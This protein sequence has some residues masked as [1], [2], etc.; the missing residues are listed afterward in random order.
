MTIATPVEHLPLSPGV[1]VS[2]DAV[3]L[4]WQLED[5]GLIVDLDDD[6]RLVLLGGV[7]TLFGPIAGA[8]VF[9]WLQDEIT[10]FDYWRLILGLL[11]IAIVL[12]F[13]QGIA[14]FARDRLG[15]WF[16]LR[17]LGE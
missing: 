2:M 8:S 15:P 9:T 14:G 3:R 16:G 11:I 4:S 17:G 1:A 10:R 12:A 7:Q 6:N 5:R 13:P